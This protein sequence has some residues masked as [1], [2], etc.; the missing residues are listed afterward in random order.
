MRPLGVGINLQ[1]NAVR[2]LYDLGIG[3]GRSRPGRP[4]GARNG[5]WSASTA[6]TSIPSRA[7]IEAG[8]RWP[9]YA[10]HRGRFHMLLHDTVVERIG[11]RAVRLGQPGHRL[12]QDSRRR[13]RPRSSS[14]P[15]ARPRRSSGALLIGADGIHSAVRAQMHPDQPP[16]HWGG[17]VMWRGTTMAKPIRTGASFVGLG[18]DRHRI[19]FY[20]ISRTR[21]RDGPGDDQLDRRSDHGQ[22]A[23]AGSRRAGSGRSGSTISSIIST[24]GSGTGWTCR[25]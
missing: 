14:A 13:R 6:T 17:A 21:P 2:E 4:A 1:P 7:G 3:D 16:I 18:T 12:P 23:R 9:Q 20:P 22:L 10:V 19:V 11:A 15:T 5:R 25:L 24:A 8:Y